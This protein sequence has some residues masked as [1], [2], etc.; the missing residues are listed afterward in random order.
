MIL[1]IFY[2]TV[3]YIAATFTTISF[4]PQ[5]VKIVKTKST[6]DVSLV[7]YLIMLTGVALWL[8]YGISINSWP[9]IVANSTTIILVGSILFIK[10]KYSKTK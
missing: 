2:D 6:K 4:L 8:F 9:M 3:G 7:M 10:W 1:T 5:L